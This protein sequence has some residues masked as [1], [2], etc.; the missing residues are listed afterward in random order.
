[1]K[2][3]SQ[4]GEQGYILEWAK[5]HRIGRFLDVGAADGVTAS[6]TR[7]L[8][9]AGWP[10]VCVE[11]AAGMFEK[12]LELYRDAPVACV[13]AAVMPF[14]ARTP[15]VPFHYSRDLVSTTEQANADTW[16]ELVS[17]ARC[18]VATVTVYDLMR[19]F[20]G[21]Y[22]FVSIDTEGTSVE[23]WDDMRRETNAFAKGA[24]VIVEAEDGG[25]RWEIQ[26]ACLEGWARVGVTPNNVILE[27]L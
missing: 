20:P 13:Q 10:G 4:T 9:L 12:L 21:P 14:E 19:V 27:R 17:F 5:Q 1:M 8:A 6:N 16:S 3:F 25:E 24:L 23:L 11:P 7:A 18:H 2:D 15:L 22:S 26:Q